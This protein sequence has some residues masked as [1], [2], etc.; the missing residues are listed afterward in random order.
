VQVRVLL[1]DDHPVV[2]DGLRRILARAEFEVVGAVT[3]GHDLVNAAASLKPDV[4]ICDI[5]MPLLNGFEATRQIHARD[6]RAKVIILSMHPTAF[7]AVEAMKSGARGYVVKSADTEELITAIRRVNAGGLY[8]PLQSAESSS[9]GVWH[10]PGSRRAGNKGDL[11]Q[12][13][14]EVLQLL[15]EGKSAKEI[16]VVLNISGRTVEFHKYRLMDA[17]SIRTVAGLAAF[18][19]RHGITA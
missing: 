13:Q 16:S 11:T 17:L 5:T 6:P 15:A 7:Y 2:L 1:A 12:R 9:N 10:R 18:A 4:I 19:A 14:Y 3:N 8:M